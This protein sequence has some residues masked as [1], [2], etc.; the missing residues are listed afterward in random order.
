MV[1]KEN[2]TWADIIEDWRGKGTILG[3]R[4]EELKTGQFRLHY[5][6]KGKPYFVDWDNKNEC[7]EALLEFGGK[8]DFTV[9]APDL[10]LKLGKWDASTLINLGH[11]PTK[12]GLKG[13]K[14]IRNQELPI[15]IP[16][17]C[18]H[19]EIVNQRKK[20][21]RDMLRLYQVDNERVNV[22]RTFKN[23]KECDTFLQFILKTKIFKDFEWD[24]SLLCT[25]A[26]EDQKHCEWR[27]KKAGDGTQR[28]VLKLLQLEGKSVVECLPYNIIS[29]ADDMVG[30][31]CRQVTVIKDPPP[32]EKTL[33]TIYAEDSV[34]PNTVKAA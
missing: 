1:K 29:A 17:K 6:D 12:I 33:C 7:Y 16:P 8:N 13:F 11:R 15:E 10:F 21:T 19:P 3:I 27:R 18:G 26:I 30:G 20:E 22:T 23:Q 2:H 31:E 28:M 32:K 5:E 25:F 34:D 4:V 24:V 9:R 14:Y